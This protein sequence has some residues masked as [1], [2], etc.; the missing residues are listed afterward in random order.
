MRIRT[1][2][3]MAFGAL[4]GIAVATVVPQRHSPVPARI[5]GSSQLRAFGVHAAAT[6]AAFE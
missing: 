4:A 2:V 5:A 6:N 1:M 3:A